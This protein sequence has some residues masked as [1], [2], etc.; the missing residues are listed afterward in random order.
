[1]CQQHERSLGKR[2]AI[3]EFALGLH[4]SPGQSSSAGSPFFWPQ[5]PNHFV[6]VLM[7]G[8]VPAA[9]FLPPGSRRF[10]PVSRLAEGHAELAS[11]ITS[12]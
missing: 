10:V 11:D 9:R 7:V 1:M 6:F 2:H 12:A 8:L 3:G 4:W 5:F